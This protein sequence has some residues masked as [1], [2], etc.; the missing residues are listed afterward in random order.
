[1]RAWSL[2]FVAWVGCAESHDGE[3]YDGDVPIGADGRSDEIVFEVPE[4][5]RSVTVVAQGDPASFLAIASLQWS[6]GTQAIEIAGAAPDVLR[7]VGTSPFPIL[8]DAPVPQLVRQGTFSWLYPRVA[9][10]PL[11]AGPARLRIAST[12]ADGSTDVTILTPLDDGAHVLHLSVASASDRFAWTEPP[13]AFDHVRATFERAGI[14][15][16]VDEVVALDGHDVGP[17]VGGYTTPDG[18]EAALVQRARAAGASTGLLVMIV[19]AFDALGYTLGLP[20]PPLPDTAYSGV[21]VSDRIP[22]SGDPDAKLGHVIA[23]EV[24]HYLGL[25]HLFDFGPNAEEIPDAFDD[26]GPYDRNLMGSLDLGATPSDE[27]TALTPRQSWAL[28]R[29]AM[30][31]AQ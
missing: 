28:S 16:V 15:V 31:V 23:H 11:P 26:T 20:G 30:L 19:D 2:L 7:Q 21:V 4:G 10:Q 27:D 5:A 17:F 8:L 22:G 1:M 25:T 14:D 9:E 13:A 18:P 3:P 12:D 24:S 6:D 29:S